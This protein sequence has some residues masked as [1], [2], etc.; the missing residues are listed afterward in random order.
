MA[1]ET[2]KRFRFSLST[3]ILIGLLLGVVT[4]L[5]FGDYCA[6]LQIIGDAFIK[7]LQM[8][9]LPYIVVSIIAGIGGLSFD[10][11]KAL[12]RKAGVLLLLFWAVGFFIILVLPLAFPHTDTGS[13]FSTSLVA[14]PKKVDFVDLY[15]PANPFKSLA[16]NVVP[17]VVLFSLF[18]GIALMGAKEK[19]IIIKPL[20][21]LSNALIRVANYVVYLTPIG[22]FAIA[23]SAAGTMTVAEFGRLQ[24]YFI[25]FFIGTVVLTFWILPLMV[26]AFTPFKYKDIVGVSKDALM[27]GFTTGNLF[28]ILPVLI[29]NCKS[30]FEQYKL[31]HPDIDSSVDIIVPVSFNFPNLGKL[32]MLLFILFAGWFYGVTVS[33]LDYP[34]FIFSGLFSFFG[35]VDVAI[36]FMLDLLRIPADAFQLYLV[37]GVVNGR[38]ATLL[39]A[40]N[41]VAFTLMATCA[42]TGLM[43]IKWR[44][45]VIY[46]LVSVVLT[47]GLTLGSRVYLT[48]SLQ[49]LS[50]A[51]DTRITRMKLMTPPQPVVIRK[52]VPAESKVVEANVSRLEAIRQRGKI[53]VGYHKDNLPFSF[54]NRYGDLVGL[55]IDIAHALADNLGVRIEFIP[56]DFGSLNEL[57]AE[58]QVD[59]ALSGIPILPGSL[60][61][62]SFSD[63]Y[64]YTNWAFVVEDHLRDQF[65][66]LENT[67]NMPG[68]TI[69]VS[70]GADAAFDVEREWPNAKAVKLESISEFFVSGQENVDCLLVS[71]EAGSAWTLLH[72]EFQVVVPKPR[73][74]VQPMGIP[75]AGGDQ[76]LLNYLNSWIDVAKKH[77]LIDELHDHWILGRGAEEKQ[78]RWSII[79]DVLGW[80]D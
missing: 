45:V 4:G 44:K 75:V 66:S 15:I 67:Q 72:P 65:A 23:A 1:S 79:R 46:S 49:S 12:A 20:S 52:S 35:S 62:M 68:L 40:M 27:T 48:L 30:L 77:K 37:T 34:N 19:E 41:L 2:E 70:T 36:P 80:I 16:N 78:P 24:V 5:F 21:T 69:G 8:S 73:L 11:A 17:A 9:I 53:R 10:R 47:V 58:D 71:A 28:I 61:V 54:F 50:K 76:D 59:I 64:L 13:F 14:P 29:Q 18:V 32:L 33:L 51:G 39:A 55:D 56:F 42:I 38:L 26:A 31:D 7:L 25:T 74:A 43:A 60:R 57:L 3:N 6:R 63:A 22:V